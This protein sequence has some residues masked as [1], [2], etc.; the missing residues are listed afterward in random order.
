MIYK[1]ETDGWV[2]MTESHPVD[3]KYSI[4]RFT[5]SDTKAGSVN[6]MCGGYGKEWNKWRKDFGYKAVKCKM[7]IEI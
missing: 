7:T 1:I 3:G 6:L 5:I 2:I 4:L